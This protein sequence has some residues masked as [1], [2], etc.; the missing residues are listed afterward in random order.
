MVFKLG[1]QLEREL[2]IGIALSALLE[3]PS[4]SRLTAMLLGMMNETRTD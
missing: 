1:A 4:V 3:G 2:G